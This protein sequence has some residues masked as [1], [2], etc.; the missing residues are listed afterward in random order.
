MYRRLTWVIVLLILLTSCDFSNDYISVGLEQKYDIG[1]DT[2]KAFGDASFQLFETS[3]NNDNLLLRMYP[4]HSIIEIDVKNYKVDDKTL[5]VYGRTGYSVINLITNEV[6]QY[7]V[8][9]DYSEDE[10]YYMSLQGISYVENGYIK[11]IDSYEDFSED[12]REVF[13]ELKK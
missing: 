10:M 5:Y 4:S 13:E 9:D 1:K 12:Q 3:S 11:V 7:Q 2:I 6:V 8:F